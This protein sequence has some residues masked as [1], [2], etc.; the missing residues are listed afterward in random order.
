MSLVVNINRNYEQ[1]NIERCG[2][3][4]F[5]LSSNNGLF[6]N[7][8]CI[9]S[10][11]PPINVGTPGSLR[12][13]ING[14][15]E[16]SIPCDDKFLVDDANDFSDSTVTVSSPNTDTMENS[17]SDDSASFLNTT[18]YKNGDTTDD[19]NPYKVLRGVKISNVNRLI[20]GQLNINSVR[21]KFEALKSIVSGNLD[22]LVLTESK[23]DDSFPI[24]QFI[25]EGYSPPFRLD[26]NGNG[27]GVLIYVR[28]DIACKILQ[29]HTSPKNLEG[30]FLELNLKKSKWLLFG[31]YNPNKNN[32]VNFVKAVGPILDHYLPKY[33]NF[34]ILGDFNSEMCEDPMREFCDTYNLSNLIKEPT[35]YKNPLNPSLIDLI[36]TN[37]PR[38]F[39]HNK[40]IETGLSDHHKLTITV[41][42]AFFPKQTPT[43]ITHRNFKDVDQELFRK[44]LLREFTNLNR[45]AIDYD[46]FQTIVMRV[47]DHHAPL[48]KKY[49]RANNLPFMNKALSKAV[50]NRSRLRNKF[51]KDPSGINKINYTKYRNYCTRLFRKEKKSY[52]SNLDMNLITDNRKFWKTIKPLFSE[53]HFS[54]NKI[55]LLDGDEIISN[56]A[57]VARKFNSF[58][59]NVVNN[60]NI[61]GFHTD[62]CFDPEVDDIS[63]IIEKFKAHPSIVKIKENV[64]VDVKFIF[65]KVSESVINKK[66]TSLDRRKPSTYNNIPTRVLVENADIIS[67]FLTD[68]YNDSVSTSKFPARL[69]CADITPTHKKN[70]RIIEDNYRPISI[71]PSVSK[72]YERMMHEE[73]FLFVDKFL[74]PSLFGFRKGFNTQQCLI[75]MLERWKRAIDQGKF[76]GAL[77]TDLSKAFDCLNHELM[78]AKLEAY[79]F[80][81]EALSYIYSYLT[82]RIQRTKVNGSFSDWADI[83]SG[84]PQGSILGPL[85]FNIYINDIFFFL[86][87]CDIANYAD[88]NTPYATDAKIS[89]LLQKLYKDTSLLSRWFKNNFLQMNADK[90][91]LLISKRDKDISIILE[92]EIIECDTSVKLLGVTIDNNLKFTEHISKM[93][94][95]ISS[96]LHALMRISNYMTRDKLRLVMKSFI[97]SQFSYCPLVWMFHSRVLNNRINRLHERGLRL[98]YKDP[99]LTFEELLQKDNSFTIHH[100]NLQKLATEMFK[101]YND[102]SPSL[103]KTIFPQRDISYDLRHR[104]PFRSENVKT[105]FNGTETLSFRGP[106]TWDLVPDLIKSS[107]S[108]SV[109]KNK[110]KNWKPDGC[111]C[112]LCKVYINDLGFL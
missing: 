60:L 71:L 16:G 47:L 23:L 59:S 39:L 7:H 19:A 37:R 80:E 36:L 64:K 45:G 69:K 97:E 90:C 100:R 50:M 91:H 42:R 61:E 98:V 54:S 109:F 79:G 40:V 85:L 81:H 15:N 74:S 68:I 11:P 67:P 82:G 83:S 57:D 70:D 92:N 38:S 51:L 95:K 17:L 2:L 12:Y 25:I 107:K 102:L 56:D 108:L 58:F 76:A 89:N 101:V 110:I 28:E 52:Y 32:I 73:I 24:A 46:T 87:E 105:V 103:L 48:K 99:H 10:T 44:D 35:C 49:L 4:N 3:D 65:S 5:D 93:C 86:T 106:K 43:I 72:V 53:K 1:S 34:L 84:V 94:K 8:F 96:K 29:A 111:T 88:D 22:I 78:I 77:L 63:N 13:P 14:V 21:N 27:G 112:R 26:R 41:M 30:I 31:G 104:N 62:Y 20:I 33:E 75:V 6:E 66:I 9:G 55:I 18:V